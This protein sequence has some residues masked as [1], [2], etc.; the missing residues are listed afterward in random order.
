MISGYVA[1]KGDSMFKRGKNA[2]TVKQKSNT[3]LPEVKPEKINN[4]IGKGGK[5]SAIPALQLNDKKSIIGESSKFEGKISGSGN[6][7]INGL[8]KGDVKLEENSLTIGPN[9]RVEGDIIVKDA[10]VSGQMIGKVTAVRTICITQHADFCGEIKAKSISID[11][12]A[13]IKAKIELD[14]EPNKN[15][16]T[17]SE[18][19]LKPC[20][21]HN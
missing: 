15:I 9:G 1:R 21:K 7:I 10:V 2:K 3:N 18:L 6:L 5:P 8:V 19:V 20:D 16:E 14:R 13:F 11:D 4:S 17:T 12:G